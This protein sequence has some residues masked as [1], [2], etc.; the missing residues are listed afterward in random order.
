DRAGQFLSARR[1]V[2]EPLRSVA[3]HRS[4][5]AG[6][7]RPGGSDP[8]LDGEP[9][10]AGALVSARAAAARFSTRRPAAAIDRRLRA[11]WPGDPGPLRARLADRA[12]AGPPTPIDRLPD[13]YPANQTHFI[14]VKDFQVDDLVEYHRRH[15][16]TR[17]PTHP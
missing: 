14:D 2:R 3:T 6:A 8:P 1:P 13:H 7:A 11:V 15:A 10:A 17:E 12:A 16:E 4:A 9:R 5:R